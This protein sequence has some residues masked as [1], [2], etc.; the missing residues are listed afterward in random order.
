MNYVCSRFAGSVPEVPCSLI[1]INS[2]YSG[3]YIISLFIRTTNIITTPSILQAVLSESALLPYII[4]PRS[5]DSAP[6]CPCEAPPPTT[7]L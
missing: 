3:N 7:Y 2:F 4:Y 6:E 1:L 5:G